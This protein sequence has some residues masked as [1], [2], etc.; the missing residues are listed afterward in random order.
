[1]LLTDIETTVISAFPFSSLYN[2]KKEANSKLG[3]K[4]TKEAITKMKLRFLD[5]KNHPMFGKKHD[6]FS[7]NL[8]SKPG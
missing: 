7:L 5:K 8:L 3:Y 2:I 6:K 4:H 1:M